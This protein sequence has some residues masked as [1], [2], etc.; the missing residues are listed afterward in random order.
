MAAAERRE[1]PLMG[2]FI[3]ACSFFLGDVECSGMAACRGRLEPHKEHRGVIYSPS[4]PMNYPPSMNCSWYIQGDYG[5][6]ITIS[7]QNFDLENSHKCTVDWLMIGPT[8]K[9][10]EYRMCG[11]YTPQPFISTRDHA[12]IFFH[13]DPTSSGRS[14]GFRLSYVRG[15]LTQS[16]CKPDEFLC[17]NGKCILSTWR[18]ND[19]DECG[20][21]SDE[22]DCQLP[23]TIPHTS[24]C[25]AR[26]FRCLV[27]DVPQC[28]L[29]KVRCDGSMDCDQGTDEENCPDTSCG[30]RMANFYGSFASPDY[31][32]S[33]QDRAQLDC[34]WVV[35][36]QDSR[37]IVLQL[38]LQ[39]GYNDKMLMYDGASK[40]QSRLLQALTFRNNGHTITI[41]SSQGQITVFY[42]SDPGSTGHGF[43][44]TY[45]VKGYCLP[46]QHPCGNDGGCFADT[47][48]C[49]GWWHC[50]NGKDEEN[51][52][53]CQKD[54]YPCGGTSGMCYPLADRCNNQK[55]C[56]DGSDEKN[57]FS[58]QPGN[59]HCGTKICIFEQWRCD[60]QEDCQDGSDEQNCLVVVP[61]KVITAALIGSLICGLLLVIA[62]G[63]AFK[64]YS[65][66]TREYRA[67][68]TPMTRLE[69]DFVQR[70][71]PPS[72]GQLIA[73][74]LIPPVDDF[75]VYNPA[76]A[77]VL[78]NLRSAMRRQIRR[79]ATR[80]MSPRGRLSRIWSRF[81]QRPRGWGLIPL[82]TPTSASTAPSS[83][84][85]QSETVRNCQQ[86][87][88]RR[89]CVQP[90]QEP[91]S[92]VDTETDRPVG[93]TS[94][95][96]TD[97]LMLENSV[98]K[99]SSSPSSDGQAELQTPCLLHSS[100]SEETCST[101]FDFPLRQSSR[102]SCSRGVRIREPLSG[103]L[104]WSFS[105][106]R[107]H[108]RPGSRTVSM[109]SAGG[110]ARSSITM[111]ITVLG[112][113]YFSAE[114]D[115][116]QDPR[117]QNFTSVSP[118]CRSQCCSCPESV[119]E[120]PCSLSMP[121]HK[122]ICAESPSPEPSF[123][124]PFHQP[125]SRSDEPALLDC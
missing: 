108:F 95:I 117:Q 34:T 86:D 2:G 61:R 11:S 54:E 103:N 25:S 99:A 10:E 111:N 47:Q 66:R 70:E 106:R 1:V 91:D 48:R 27:N 22:Q 79:H 118:A 71:A 50:P 77:S 57:C 44:A 60:G 85:D 82:L 40:E 41:E 102:S 72:Y 104:E 120:R 4:W 78:Q 75:P 107:H 32:R 105:S 43:N 124:N 58:C 98:P 69:A 17:G 101:D 89:N 19:M 88:S 39:L 56:P 26:T 83:H 37:H 121:R 59:F 62:L 87:E 119:T 80:R 68:D 16:S 35:D 90:P 24:P 18:C 52:A 116:H 28:L 64:L 12:W 84:L 123:R 7:F 23:P 93:E 15:R 9:R 30:K 110:R 29:M 67:F 42:H 38:N 97:A 45:Q 36:T 92:D 65:L 94:G 21:N 113:N 13:S 115:R 122:H 3:L 100:S 14:R 20:D 114:S 81:F 49:D 96:T 55:N 53:A 51:C 125:D 46:Q 112:R 5:D 33:Q 73:Q 74:G 76:Q 6:L 63:C 8:P 31:F 109:R